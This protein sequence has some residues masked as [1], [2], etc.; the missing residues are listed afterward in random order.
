MTAGRTFISGSEIT[1]R[2]V[3]PTTTDGPT[4]VAVNT[5]GTTSRWS[6]DA[7]DTGMSPGSSGA[8]GGAVDPAT[9]DAFVVTDLGGLDRVREIGPTRP[10]VALVDDPAGSFATDPAV[11]A[12]TTDPTAVD[13]H[14]AWLLA[15]GDASIRDDPSE[16]PSRIE[17]LQTGTARLATVRSV[18]EAYR[19]TTVIAD[20]VFPEYHVGVGVVTD[21][22]IEPVTVS[23]NVD[24]DDCRRVRVGRGSAGTALDRSEPVITPAREGDGEQISVPVGDEAV[25]QVST[26]NGSGFDAGDERLVELLASHLEETLERLRADTELR[27]E[28]DRLLALFEN[29]PDSAVAYD[30][31]EAGP[32]FR[33]V[34][35]A[36]EETFG[37]DAD[38]VVG[39]PMDEYIV[40]ETEAEQS[41]ADELNAKLR[42][43]EN[44]RREVTRQT[45]DGERHFILH[46]IPIHLDAENV[47][48]YAIYTDVTE[49]REREATLRRQN[50]RLEEFSS[51]V[52]HDLRNPLS[53]A[54]G[55]VDLA[56]D[57]GDPDHLDHA[58]DALTRMDRLVRDLLS[59]ARKGEVVG[60]VEPIS[61][62]SVARD[63]WRSVDT[64]DAALDVEADVRL[65]ADATRTR[66]LLENLFRNSVE[67]GSTSNRTQSGDSVEHGSTGSRAGSG[68]GAGDGSPDGAERSDPTVTVRIGSLGSGEGAED[69]G[70]YVEDDGHGFTEDPDHVFET[71]YTTDED[72]TG[73]GLAI[74]RRIAEAHGW[75]PRAT[76]GEGGGARF[77]FRAG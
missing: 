27:A 24:L 69:L 77:E 25:L 33:R 53:V 52:S 21:G 48:G 18:E 49:R 2:I 29:V 63:A 46:V 13:R 19:T 26:G 60:E 5:D 38:T 32:R 62:A 58:A 39:E 74:V 9:A 70:F 61:I 15:R 43:G 50:E 36:F 11:D 73:L 55:Y 28:R 37:Y 1:H 54:E 76:T 12:I 34:N 17:R 75:E 8:D 45:I 66:E 10:V 51:I 4:V 64:G 47:A 31:T 20:E 7:P 16:E 14:V 65:D 23:A 35:P 44:V 72:G 6:D 59:L 30:F 22:W 41:E 67:H 3:V 68:D 71:G 57:T 42:R 56:R 40:P